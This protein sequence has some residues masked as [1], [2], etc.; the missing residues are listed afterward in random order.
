MSSRVVGKNCIGE[1]CLEYSLTWYYMNPYTSIT[2]F[3]CHSKLYLSICIFFVS[4]LPSSLIPDLFINDVWG[5]RRETVIRNIY[6]KI[7]IGSWENQDV[8]GEKIVH[9]LLRDF[10]I[11]SNIPSPIIF[12]VGANI[13]DYVSKLSSIFPNAMIYCFEPNPF[14]YKKLQ[15]HASNKISTFKLGFGNIEKSSLIYTYPNEKASQHASLY[16]DVITEL[17]DSESTKEIEIKITTLDTFTAKQKIEHINILKI[18]TEGY[19]LSVLHGSTKL[20][21]NDVIDFVLFEFNEMNVVS[22]VF[23]KDFYTT[24]PNYSF[25]RISETGLIPLGK[26]TPSNEHFIIQNILAI[27]NDLVLDF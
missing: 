8:S 20:I 19:E 25:Y 18:D 11:K 2:S 22:R 1:P 12:D 16:R 5:N 24:L 23:L 26:Y 6:R 27:R 17:H 9:Q 7:G 4:R 3:L 21:K 14:A 13:G 15:L 10:Y